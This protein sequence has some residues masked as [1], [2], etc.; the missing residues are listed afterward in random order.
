MHRIDHWS[1]RADVRQGRKCPRRPPQEAR[2]LALTVHQH[3]TARSTV[4]ARCSSLAIS[5]ALTNKMQSKPCQ[6]LASCFCLHTARERYNGHAE[7]HRRGAATADRASPTSTPNPVREERNRNRYLTLSLL[8]IRKAGGVR[9]LEAHRLIDKDGKLDVIIRHLD[10]M[11]ASSTDTVSIVFNAC[12][13]L[14]HPSSF[15]SRPQRS[16]RGRRHWSLRQTH[17][18]P[19]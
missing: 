17:I 16:T 19:V 18:P 1:A 2:W 4:R 3:H 13:S 15:A 9:S 7:S 5:A 11:S 8:C 14:M 10:R 6:S 12:I